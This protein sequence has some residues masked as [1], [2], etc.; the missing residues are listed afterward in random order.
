[1]DISGKLATVVAPVSERTDRLQRVAAEN[2]DF[3]VLTVGDVHESLFGIRRERHVIDR[4]HAVH[5]RRERLL[6]EGAVLAKYL[7]AAAR[8]V[9]DVQQPVAAHLD[10]VDEPELRRWW[11]A[12]LALRHWFVA[13]RLAVGTPHPLERH[14]V[15]VEHN[16][17][18]VVVAV[19][20]ERLVRLWIEGYLRRLGIVI[21]VGVP[22]ALP[23]FPLL[24]EQRAVTRELTE[25]TE[26]LCTPPAL[27]RVG[28]G[29]HISFVIY[30]ETM[31]PAMRN[32]SQGTPGREEVEAMPGK[33]HPLET[34]G[35]QVW[36]VGSPPRLHHCASRVELDHGWHRVAALAHAAR[37]V[38]VAIR[39]PMRPM[40][41]PDVVAI[42]DHHR[43]HGAE[44]SVIGQ[45][46]LRPGRVVLEHRS[47]ASE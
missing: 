34:S 2:P 47:T 11:V 44:D 23:V 7:K 42:V 39:D 14:G 20:Y 36:I 15:G 28:S 33:F 27:R 9:A 41:D 32:V 26:D 30:G 45:W 8:H 29:P 1:M 12:R 24:D 19:G 5:A 40:H 18:A 10:A 21:G 22:L 6:H 13:R 16:Y 3:P 25:A 38:I 37:S 17:A 4:P 43:Q 31:C 46:P 35:R